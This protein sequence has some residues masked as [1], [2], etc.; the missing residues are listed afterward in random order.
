MKKSL[1]A[2]AVA[3]AMTAP[4]VAQ[5][6]ATLFGEMVYYVTDTDGSDN[7]PSAFFDT[8]LLGVEGTVEN[9]IDGL[10]TGFY[11]ETEWDGETSP[12]VDVGDPAADGGMLTGAGDGNTWEAAYVYMAGSWGQAAFGLQDN[13][14]NAG[15]RHVGLEGGALNYI[16][17]DQDMVQGIVYSTPDMGGFAASLGTVMTDGDAD[18]STVDATVA[19]V[20]F[21]GAGFE[22][23]LGYTDASDSWDGFTLGGS[24][25]AMDNLSVLAS[26]QDLEADGVSGDT[27]SWNIGAEYGIGN[28]TLGIEYADLD[29]DAGITGY[30]VDAD[31]ENDYV[32]LNAT[33]ALG[34][35]AYVAAEYLDFDSDDSDTLILAYGLEF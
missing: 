19:S 25:Q 33:Y 16:D 24:V 5:A 14:G 21:E 34:S 29:D 10:E 7:S 17:D 30:D 18:D 9:D 12:G 23:A 26:Y 2:L 31:G 11:M 35:S 8:I 32:L 27:K 6:D 1:I 28:T 15:S 13:P 20:G 4:V 3:G 22:V